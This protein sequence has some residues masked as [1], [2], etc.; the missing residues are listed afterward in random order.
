MSGKSQSKDENLKDKIKN[1][2]RRK[3]DSAI[4]QKGPAR[5][6]STVFTHEILKDIGPESPGNNRI[7]T[8]KELG[9]VVLK[10]KL[11]EN[12]IEAVWC[13]IQDL[14][15]PQTVSEKRH[16]ALQFLMYLLEGQYQNLGKLRC[17]FFHVIQ[18][19]TLREN[20]DERLALF[21]ILSEQGK[22]LLEFEEEA[23]MFLLS[24][25]PEVIVCRKICDFLPLLISVVKFNAAYLDEEVV[26]GIIKQTCVICNRPKVEDQVFDDEIK[27]SLDL[28]ASVL[29]Y[30]YLP[31]DTLQDVVG[32]LCRMVNIRKYCEPSWGLMRK[33]LG[34]HLGH[35]T[36][37]TMCNMLQSRKQPI[38]YTLL[39]GG[40]FYI[41]MA[42][43]GSR[44]VAFL[45][46][47][48]AAVLPSFLHVLSSGN[49]MI[50][51]EVTLS[52]QRL[53]K[54]YGKDLPGS[55]WDIILDIVETVLKQL[56]TAKDLSGH[57]Q[58]PVEL[59]DTLTTIEQLHELGQFS[60]SVDRFFTIIEMCPAKRP[61]NSVILLIS[62]LVQNIDPVKESWINNLCHLLDRYFRIEGRTKIRLKALDVLS[63]VLSINK[64]LYEEDLIHQVVLPHLCHIESDENVNIRKCSVEILIGLAQGCSPSSFLDVINVVEKILNCPL[65]GRHISPYQA[66]DSPEVIIDESH[67]IDVKT[68]VVLLVDLFKSKLYTYPPGICVKLYDLLLTHLNL[69]F[70]EPKDYSGNT[71]G[72]VRKTIIECLLNLRADVFHRIGMYDRQSDK[73]ARYSP[74]VTCDRNERS[75]P[76]SPVSPT[77]VMP[78][79]VTISYLDYTRTFSIFIQCLENETDWE[80]LKGVLENLPVLLQN[81]TIILSSTQANLV[82]LLCSKLCAMV[83]DRQ[84]RFPE[85]L[86]GAPAKLTRSDFHAYV[87]PVLAAMVTYHNYL[88]RNRQR[89]LIKCLEFGMVSKLAKSCVN[90][91]RLCTLEMQ[92]VMM[93]L[94]PLV[95]LQLS[96]ISAT[97]SMAIPV[98]AFLSSIVRL[99]KMYANFVEDEYMSV[100]A[101][102]LPYTNP[103]KFSHY[104]VSLAH[105]VI[106]IWYIRCRLPF[107]KTFVQ[108]IQKGLRAN[109]LQQ[110]EEN[111][112]LA[113]QN[114]NQDSSDRVRSGSYS[115]AALRSRRRMQSGSAVQRSEVNAPMD[116][117]LS[118]FHRELTETCTD[119]MAR[120][121]FG[122]FSP[123]P[124]RSNMAEFLL[125]G[126]QCQSWLVGN[127]LITITTSG[128]GNKS[129]NS[130]VCE[131]CLAAY[132][133][134]EQKDQ[135]GGRRRHRSAV[136]FSRSSSTMEP[137]YKSSQD[138]FTVQSKTAFDDIDLDLAG[139][140][141]GVQTGSSL[142]D[143]NVLENE[144]LESLILGMK[145]SDPRHLPLNICNCWCTN[146]AEIYIRAPSGNLSWMMRIENEAGL[147]NLSDS[148]VS[149][150]TM[151][152]ASMGKKRKPDVTRQSHRIES[153][154]IGEEEYE[155]LYKQHFEHNLKHDRPEVSAGKSELPEIAEV[156][157]SGSINRP[158]SL[159]FIVSS[160]EE[161]SDTHQVSDALQIPSAE[162]AKNHDISP[163]S[164]KRSNSSP[165][166]MSGSSDTL[167]PRDSI[168]DIVQFGPLT[169]LDKQKPIPKSVDSDKSDN[170]DKSSRPESA[171]IDSEEVKEEEG[172]KIVKFDVCDKTDGTSA[173]SLN[174]TKSSEEKNNQNKAP[175]PAKL[176]LGKEVSTSMPKDFTSML[177]RQLSPSPAS[178]DTSSTFD[179][180]GELPSQ[181]P[182][183][184]GHTVSVVQ[185]SNARADNGVPKTS[186]GTGSSDNSKVGVSPSFVFLQLYHSG[187]VQ[188]SD[189]PLLLP[190]ND[191]TERAIKMLDHIY[192]YETHKIGVI[193]VGPNQSKD[194]KA[195]L[196][197][198]YGSDRYMKFIQ[199][200]GT[201]FRLKDCNPQHVYLGGLDTKGNDGEFSYGWQDES[202]Q[203]IF[204]IATL[205]PNKDSDPNCNAKKLHIGNDYVTVVYNDSG[206]EYKIGVMKGQFNYVNIVIKPLDYNSNAVTLQAKEVPFQ[207]HVTAD[208]AGILG[209]TDTKVISDTNLAALVRQIAIHCNL[210][211]MVLQRQASQPTDPFANNW[212]ERLRKIRRM[213]TTCII[214]DNRPESPSDTKCEDFTQ[215]V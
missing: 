83:N 194:E 208:I 74:Y 62:H 191:T 76:R 144:P 178:S 101:I 100:F 196:S 68:A 211:S 114:Q 72:A 143:G 89:E 168:S 47:T 167:S 120:Y 13:S 109:V 209:H 163:G 30:S 56:D 117:K 11:E 35:S 53:V 54:K 121:A 81:K 124:H 133:A 181:L 19:L 188:S 88:D 207:D 158:G 186:K 50:A 40:I 42:L 43:W 204:H 111:S 98:L 7:K 177:T 179:E 175:L 12:A 130:G 86:V 123:L 108:F 66:V 85:K 32:S 52:V 58:T 3:Q 104:T 38:D 213:K 25:M 107:R 201:L 134:V 154:S 9:D 22:C 116:G 150:I 112:R 96:K 212:L 37:Y 67:L 28:I 87:F 171:K 128:S 215:Y 70:M 27:L 82:D 49:A 174:V 6:F 18:S 197:N 119:V 39:R 200:L 193:Y 137:G 41:G 16:V 214:T 106:A 157:S 125:A 33:L 90:A 172:G 206:E 164:L 46:H 92:E 142:S 65:V 59:H 78:Q 63:F 1:L 135:R 103:F 159:G 24:W 14:F 44:K 105:H 169:K 198:T 147:L 161:I 141:V 195:I 190:N 17:H 166:I 34:T 31:S 189:V 97:M 146:W 10:K 126:G 113:L 48:P 136:V 162:S 115:E 148:Q 95:L 80:V 203:L 79:W 99:P 55:T 110:F 210:A 173:S 51:Y 36:I 102:A 118:Q 75:P 26:S 93:R 94:L 151:L 2:F 202:T 77:P 192:P 140:D 45:K 15:L 153:G 73:P 185:H 176:D 160:A 152:F 131:K 129:A 156:D 84:L 155:T 61:E 23:G 8:I 139:Q 69:H 64:H 165:S 199:S 91:L 4:L 149:D 29:G 184:R 132:Q 145:S 180:V 182:R 21:R 170:N 187:Q 60:G 5:D 205:M 183:H 138:D 20:I 57:P 71:A 122:N 127:K